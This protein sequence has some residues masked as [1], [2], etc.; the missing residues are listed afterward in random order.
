MWIIQILL[1]III[2]MALYSI[3]IFKILNIYSQDFEL[4]KIHNLKYLKK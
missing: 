2:V 4:Y 1:N 3:I